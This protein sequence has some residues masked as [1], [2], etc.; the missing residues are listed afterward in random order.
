VLTVYGR[1]AVPVVGPDGDEQA[2][3]IAPLIPYRT[4][5]RAFAV[6]KMDGTAYRVSQV[7]GAGWLCTCGDFRHR[8]RWS[9]K[10]N[11]DECKHTAAVSAKFTTPNATIAQPDGLPPAAT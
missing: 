11:R 3:L 4:E 7:N 6:T 1:P 8:H 10:R 2:Y 5:V 9:R